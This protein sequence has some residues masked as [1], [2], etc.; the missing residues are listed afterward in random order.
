MTTTTTARPSGRPKA[1]VLAAIVTALAT[2]IGGCAPGI[3]AGPSAN[4]SAASSAPASIQPTAS[5]VTAT[6]LLYFAPRPDEDA[7]GIF[8]SAPDGSDVK[9][10]Q[11]PSGMRFGMPTSFPGV[12]PDGKRFGAGMIGLPSAIF[13]S[14][15]SVVAT[16]GIANEK[17]ALAFDWSLDGTTIIFTIGPPNGDFVAIATSTADGGSVHEILSSPVKD[18]GFRMPSWAPDGTKFAYAY[19]PPDE[20]FKIWMA[21]KDGSGAQQLSHPEEG[22]FDI[23][24]RWSPDGTRILFTRALF[25]DST[26]AIWSMQADGS[27]EREMTTGPN[28]E[29]AD[30]SPDG[31]KIVVK[32]FTKAEGSFVLTMNLDGSGVTPLPDSSRFQFPTWVAF[33]G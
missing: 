15:G 5:P 12:S 8:S 14:D 21:N 4:P 25:K 30:W 17:L 23:F 31:Q 9:E 22:Y 28:D 11:R 1:A 33:P 10:I 6:R 32:R 24:P 3:T 13:N 16:I 20:Q 29:Y 7:W 27:D 18:E 19:T 26:R 2:S